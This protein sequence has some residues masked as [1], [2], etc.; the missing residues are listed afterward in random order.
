[1]GRVVVCAMTGG[2][3]EDWRFAGRLEVCG[4]TEVLWEELLFVR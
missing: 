4:K 3:R 1:M 2:L